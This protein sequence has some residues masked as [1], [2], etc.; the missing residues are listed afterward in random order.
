MVTTLKGKTKANRQLA[1]LLYIEQRVELLKLSAQHFAS[2][3]QSTFSSPDRITAIIF[4]SQLLY[5]VSTLCQRYQKLNFCDIRAMVFLR[6]YRVATPGGHSRG[7]ESKK[8]SNFCLKKWLRSL[9]NLSSGRLRESFQKQY[10][11]EKQNGYF[12][13]V[14]LRQVVAYEPG[15]RGSSGNSWGVC[16]PVLQILTLLQTKKCQFSHLFSDLASK[17]LCLYY[18]DQNAN[19]KDFLKSF[20]NSHISLSF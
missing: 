4:L 6:S 19:R 17:K 10:L 13:N 8:R 11:T 9:R 1:I 20:S 15:G 16:R 2:L 14:R 18:L 5:F 3:V 7:A 12:Q